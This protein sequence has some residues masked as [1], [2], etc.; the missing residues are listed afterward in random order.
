MNFEPH[1]KIMESGLK[2]L[3]ESSGLYATLD[4]VYYD[5]CSSMVVSCIMMTDN[6]GFHYPG[7][8]PNLDHPSPNTHWTGKL[9][10]YKKHSY[11]ICSYVYIST[12]YKISNHF[13]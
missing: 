11:K 7:I 13:K 4:T 10:L 2:W 5:E 6:F 8:T 12:S 9:L 3:Y 1:S